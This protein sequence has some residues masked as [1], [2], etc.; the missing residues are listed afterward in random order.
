MGKT[1]HIFSI[2]KIISYNRQVKY[3][4]HKKIILIIIT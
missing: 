1:F 2:K 4:I 3:M